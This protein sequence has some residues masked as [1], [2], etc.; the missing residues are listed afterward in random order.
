MR[1]KETLGRVPLAVI[2]PLDV[3]GRASD[4]FSRQPGGRIVVSEERRVGEG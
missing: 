4:T 2:L 1:V 3:H